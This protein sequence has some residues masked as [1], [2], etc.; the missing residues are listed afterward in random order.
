MTDEP[1]PPVEWV[2]SGKRWWVVRIVIPVIIVALLATFLYLQW[3]SSPS[4]N[5]ANYALRYGATFGAL[6]L[7]FVFLYAFPSVRRIGISP[8]YLVVDIGIAK[9]TYS[10]PELTQI[11]RTQVHRF[12]WNQVSSVNRTRIDV[13]RGVM[14]N[15]FALSPQQGDRLAQFLRIP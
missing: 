1:P 10:W 13:G 2:P 7:E 8:L 14:V 12:R 6:V 4:W 3:S 11:T 15:S 5:S 9:F